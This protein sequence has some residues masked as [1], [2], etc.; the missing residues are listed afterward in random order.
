MKAL[1]ITNYGNPLVVGETPMPKINDDEVLVQ[2]YAAA[3]NHIDYLKAEGILRQIYPLSF[4]WI[5]GRD[6]AGKV[7]QVGKNVT[8]LKVG[9]S[10]YGDNPNGGVYAE[11]LAVNPNVLAHKPKT[12]N[13]VEAASVPVSA[14]AAYQ[15]LFQHAKIEPHHTLLI[16]GAAGSLGSFAIQMAKEK[17][18][19]II[20]LA[21]ERYKNYLLQLGA[22]KVVTALPNDYV[23]NVDIV[24]DLVGGETQATL[25]ETLK[26]GGLLITTNQ[27]PQQE[28][29]EKYGVTAFMMHQHPSTEGLTH[30]AKVID[31]GKLKV[32]IAKVFPFEE[33]AKAWQNLKGNYNHNN[34]P[35]TEKANGK[36]VLQFI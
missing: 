21:H 5:P 10:V 35:S 34:T 17:G 15:A 32:N 20:A 3:A 11:Y 27:P 29:A 19:T 16:T 14:E 36:I 8:S 26:K 1:I 30:L 24:L 22:N 23:K 7:V 33:G 9:D 18:T 2:I 13:F 6:F 25:F 31:E 28:L 4:P 12:L